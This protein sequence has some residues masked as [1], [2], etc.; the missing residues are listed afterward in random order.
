MGQ[1]AFFQSH[2][3]YERRRPEESALLPAF[4]ERVDELGGLPA[5]VTAEFDKY[6]RCGLLEHGCLHLECRHCGDSKLVHAPRE[7]SDAART[8]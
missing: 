3:A 2:A 4:V 6:L 1:T 5:F 7:P 8:Q